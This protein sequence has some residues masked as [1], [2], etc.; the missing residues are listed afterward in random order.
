[1]LKILIS[2]CNGHMGQVVAQICRE[3]GDVEVEEGLD[4][5]CQEREYFPV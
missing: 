5:L 2:G 3:S 1:M 4:L